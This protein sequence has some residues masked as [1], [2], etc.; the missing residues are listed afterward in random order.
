MKAGQ[1]GRRETAFFIMRWASLAQT[2][3]DRPDWQCEFAITE[4]RSFTKRRLSVPAGTALPRMES[5]CGTLKTESLHRYGFTTCEQARQTMSRDRPVPRP[6]PK[7]AMIVLLH[8][9]VKKQGST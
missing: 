2:A 1:E 9:L 6:T 8:P 4:S 5:C 3:S 7:S